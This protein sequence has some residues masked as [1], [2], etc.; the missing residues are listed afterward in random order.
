[1]SKKSRA[2][3]LEALEKINHYLKPKNHKEVEIER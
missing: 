3:Q 2:I 1:M